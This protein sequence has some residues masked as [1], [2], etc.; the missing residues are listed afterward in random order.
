MDHKHGVLVLNQRI[1]T[2]AAFGHFTDHGLDGARDATLY[3]LPLRPT[4]AAWLDKDAEF[5]RALAQTD[6]KLVAI[7]LAMRQLTARD[8]V[9]AGGLVLTYRAP[10]WWQRLFGT[11][12]KWGGAVC[13]SLT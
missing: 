5:A 4:T 2:V 13:C 12:R 8:I 9:A 6:A 7:G 10:R 3:L 11:F 1:Y